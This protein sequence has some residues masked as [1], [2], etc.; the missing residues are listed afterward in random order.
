MREGI[1]IKPITVHHH[2]KLTSAM[3]EEVEEYKFKKPKLDVDDYE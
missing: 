2:S 3:S 1:K